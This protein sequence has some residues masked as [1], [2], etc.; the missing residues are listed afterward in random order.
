LEILQHRTLTHWRRLC[1]GYAAAQRQTAHNLVNDY[2]SSRAYREIVG[3]DGNVQ[4]TAARIAVQLGKSTTD[5]A[6]NKIRSNEGVYVADEAGGTVV[7][8]HGGL[9]AHRIQLSPAGLTLNM[10]PGLDHVGLSSS[11]SIVNLTQC[12]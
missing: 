1:T 7:Q 11:F 2:R 9:S 3:E 6:G 8:C 10:L 4:K 12:N 5:E